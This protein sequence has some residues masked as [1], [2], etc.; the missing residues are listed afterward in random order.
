MSVVSRQFVLIEPRTI[1]EH[2]IL[3]HV[4]DFVKSLLYIIK[5][6]PGT[7]GILMALLFKVAA[8]KKH[9]EIDDA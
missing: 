1:R 9:P 5:D 6:H 4:A 3:L 2:G 8:C 7:G